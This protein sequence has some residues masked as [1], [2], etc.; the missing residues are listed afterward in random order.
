MEDVD[1]IACFYAAVTRK[2]PSG[3][4]FFT[5]QCMTREQALRSYCLDAAYAAFEE[6]LKGSLS[7]G[8]LADIVVL[9]HDIMSCPEEE[10]RSAQVD[11]TI[12]GGNIVYRRKSD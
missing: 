4:A 11:L 7:P 10:I 5:Q 1:P 2:L 12:V 6:E 9:S 3:V 8:K